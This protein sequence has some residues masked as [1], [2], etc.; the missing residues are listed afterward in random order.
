MVRSGTTVALGLVVVALGAA[1]A[2]TAVAYD[3]SRDRAMSGSERLMNEAKVRLLV[4]NLGTAIMI[5][6]SPGGIHQMTPAARR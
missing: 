2:S 5:A 3:P 1:L 6:A 4:P